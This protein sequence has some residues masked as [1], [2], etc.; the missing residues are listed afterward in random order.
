MVAKFGAMLLLVL[1]A[2]GH[3]V[4]KDTEPSIEDLY[5]ALEQ[6]DKVK[7]TED[8][9][10]LCDQFVVIDGHSIRLGSVACEEETEGV[11]PTYP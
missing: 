8:P 6:Y 5:R 7:L 1:S 11:K 2:T 9:T 3:E 10:L 4:V